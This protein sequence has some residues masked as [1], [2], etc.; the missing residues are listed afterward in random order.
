[1]P[2]SKSCHLLLIWYTP[3]GIVF[4]GPMDY[5]IAKRETAEVHHSEILRFNLNEQI[6]RLNDALAN[7]LYPVEID[8]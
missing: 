5:F 1:M 7:S 3:V 2:S 4:E 8:A 6:L